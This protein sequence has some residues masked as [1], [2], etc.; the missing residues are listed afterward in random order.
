MDIEKKKIQLEIHKMDANIMD[1]EIRIEERKM[2]IKRIEDQIKTYKERKEE[3]A[4]KLG[5]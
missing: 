4:V 2:E 5:E 3:L 1:S